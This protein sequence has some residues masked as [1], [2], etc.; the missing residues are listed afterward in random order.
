MLMENRGDTEPCLFIEPYCEKYWLKP[1]E[2]FTVRSEAEGVDVWFDT[3]VSKG[4]VTVWLSEDGGPCKVV[5]DYALVDASGTRLDSGHQRTGGSVG[6][7][8]AWCQGG[9]RLR[10]RR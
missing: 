2:V 4:C 6:R 7:P 9:P 8:L 3:H 10:P 1:G 5:V